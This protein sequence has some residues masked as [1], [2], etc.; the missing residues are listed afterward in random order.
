MLSLVV[1]VLLTSCVAIWSGLAALTAGIWL[2]DI[3]KFHLRTSKDQPG[4][5]DDVESPQEK[6]SVDEISHDAV[7]LQE[8]Q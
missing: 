3:Y 5:A 7:D 6:Q 2:L 4:T 1:D 8:Q